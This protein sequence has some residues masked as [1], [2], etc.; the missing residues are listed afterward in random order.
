MKCWAKNVSTDCCNVQSEEHYIS[1]GL[2]SSEL[3]RVSGFDFLKGETKEIPIKKLVRNCLCERHNNDLS[4]VD[5]EAIKLSEALEYAVSLHNERSRKKPKRWSVHKREV[6]YLKVKQWFVK[7][8]LGMDVFFTKNSALALDTDFLAKLAFGEADINQYVSLEIGGKVGED[9]VID[10]VVSVSPLFSQTECVG[11]I[12]ELY[13]FKVDCKIGDHAG[14]KI[15][16]KLKIKVFEHN[17]LSY[18]INLKS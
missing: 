3:V 14:N 2:F 5:A 4:P 11:I 18:E 9:M 17:H 6:D 12:V 16:N 7:T 1:K 8:I 15:K 13:G 10:Q